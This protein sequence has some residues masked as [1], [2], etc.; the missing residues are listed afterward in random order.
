MTRTP[1]SL[2]ARIRSDLAREGDPDRA[3]GMQAYMK[4]A[5]PFFGVRVPQVRSITRAAARAEPALELDA[6]AAAARELFDNATHREERYAALALLALPIARGE[7]H[8]IPTHEHFATAGAWWDIVDE[9]AHRI[10]DL[11]DAHPGE[12]ARVVRAWSA[13]DDMWLRRL[14]IISQLGRK[15]RV[16]AVLLTEVVEANMSDRE[17][18]I[19]KAIGWALRDYARVQPGWVSDFVAA[20][21]HQLSGLSRREA[22]KHL[23]S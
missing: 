21:E 18:F 14:A 23:A 19:R 4:S 10:A 5:L 16:D 17:F 13:H 1:S 11:H 22:L 6:L 3:P 7:L 9:T 8:L 12:T 15:D 20:H 2:V